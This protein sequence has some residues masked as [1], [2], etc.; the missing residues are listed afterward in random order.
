MQTR[1][2]VGFVVIPLVMLIAALMAGAGALGNFW[3]APSIMW[4]LRL[5]AYAM[6]IVACTSLLCQAPVAS[7][8]LRAVLVI[9]IVTVGLMAAKFMWDAYA[10]MDPRPNFGQFVP[11]RGGAAEMAWL[12]MPDLVGFAIVLLGAFLIPRS[13]IPSK[14]AERDDYEEE[15]ERAED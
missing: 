10:P 7:I 12:Q 2:I 9:W 14:P 4:M 5:T 8:P 15:D 1:D 11:N 6:L 13:M 3:I